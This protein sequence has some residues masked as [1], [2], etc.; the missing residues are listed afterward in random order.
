MMRNGVLPEEDDLL[1][2]AE[3]L[4]QEDPLLVEGEDL[5]WNKR[6]FLFWKNFFCWKKKILF[7]WNKKIFVFF[8]FFFWEKRILFFQ[9]KEKKKKKKKK[10]ILFDWKKKIFAD[11]DGFCATDCFSSTA[12]HGFSGMGVSPTWTG[13]DQHGTL[14]LLV[15]VNAAWLMPRGQ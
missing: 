2:E 13:T 3:D 8:V 10:N 1:L 9:K 15:M 5:L 4:L 7:F 12:R 11:R 14:L 6:I